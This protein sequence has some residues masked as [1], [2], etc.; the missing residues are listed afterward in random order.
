MLKIVS[1]NC[2]SIRKNIEKVK[3]LAMSYDI[4]M[5]QELML[6]NDDAS[7]LSNID[8]NYFAY[9]FLKDKIISDVNIGRPTKGVAFLINKTL[10]DIVTPL[11]INES[12]IALVLNGEF[13]KYLLINVYMPVDRQNCDSFDEFQTELALISSLIEEH[14]I[15]NVILAGDFNANLNKISRW[16]E[17]LIFCEQ[18]SLNF[19]DSKLPPDSFTYLS[20]GNDT[21]SWL[22]HVV[23]SVHLNDILCELE[24]LHDFSIY[25]HFPIAFNINIVLKNNVL[26][27]DSQD[28][29]NSLFDTSTFV[30]WDK[31]KREEIVAYQTIIEY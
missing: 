16:R 24:I 1:F 14:N 25:D 20:P 8:K 11:F 4:I 10:K 31:L 27:N 30:K 9:Y 7:I 19:T 29:S 5:L 26:L 13:K 6:M 23:C 21:V 17:L 3:A 2:N 22:D 15:Y 28:T 18:F 12:I